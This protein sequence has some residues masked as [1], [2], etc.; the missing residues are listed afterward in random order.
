[1]PTLSDVI[2]AWQNREV[3]QEELATR[4]GVT[5]PVISQIFTGRAANPRYATVT[6]ICNAWALIKR[7]RSDKR[8]K[9]SRRKKPLKPRKAAVA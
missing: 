8:A 3:T 6:A 7:E 9:A 5:Q 4:A 1:M 2:A